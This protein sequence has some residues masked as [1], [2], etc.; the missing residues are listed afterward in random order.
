MNPDQLFPSPRSAPAKRIKELSARRGELQV[1][2]R[3]LTSEFDQLTRQREQY[4]A[5]ITQAEAR[6]LGLGHGKE[7]LVAA[8]KALGQTTKELDAINLTPI[9]GAIGAVEEEITRILHEDAAELQA[10]ISEDAEA[11]ATAFIGALKRLSEAREAYR[12]TWIRADAFTRLVNDPPHPRVSELP[13]AADAAGKGAAALAEAIPTPRP[14]VLERGW[15]GA[16][17][18]D[19]A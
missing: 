10:E 18:V 6:M 1:E 2:H 8:R 7:D 3:Q 4:E 17:L 11:V 13:Q 15:P 16:S 19:A 14:V 9:A 5:A 12:T